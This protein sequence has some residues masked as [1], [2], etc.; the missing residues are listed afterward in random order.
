M[1]GSLIP[2][3]SCSG[4]YPDITRFFSV[5]TKIGTCCNQ[6]I[7]TTNYYL[8]LHKLKEQFCKT[9]KLIAT[10]ILRQLLYMTV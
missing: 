4:E 5:F 7:N 8:Q 3:T 10:V 6:T 2:E 9:A 1:N